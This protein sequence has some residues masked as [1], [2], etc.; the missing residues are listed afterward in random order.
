MHSNRH[1]V[2]PFLG[3][4]AVRATAIAAMAGLC[5]LLGC[6]RGPSSNS[7][8]GDQA[9]LDSPLGVATALRTWHRQGRY[10]ELD[11]YVVTDQRALMVDTLM[12]LS[13]ML[14]ANDRA[15]RLLVA[16]HGEMLA[17]DFDLSLLADHLGLFSRNV[18]F[19]SER[20]DG[21]RAI[22][23]AQ[24]AGRVP[25]EEY[26]FLR[27]QGRWVYA[28][29]SPMPSLPDLIRQLAVGLELFAGAIENQSLSPKQVHSEFKHRVVTRVKRIRSALNMEGAAPAP[30]SQPP[31]SRPASRPAP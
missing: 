25:L 26:R 20:I 29:A 31:A 5:L 3:C 12:A 6:E 7:E 28:P 27:Q 4:A 1:R 30:A 13:R 10:R 24:V 22:V 23:S 11:E 15:Q 19:C 2:I 21:D 16:H 9:A 14:Q 8:H 18:E 17:A